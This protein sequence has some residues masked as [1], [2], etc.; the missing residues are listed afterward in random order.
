LGA[1]AYSHPIAGY[2]VDFFQRTA[3]GAE[4]AEKEKREKY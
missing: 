3:E 1:I 2:K 4:G